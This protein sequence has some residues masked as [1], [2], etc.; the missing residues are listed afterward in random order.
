MKTIRNNFFKTF[1]LAFLLISSSAFAGGNEKSPLVKT[2]LVQQISNSFAYPDFANQLNGNQNVELTFTVNSDSTL[3][4]KSVNCD[5][6]RVEMYVFKSLN[7]KK[8]EVDKS[9]INK[10]FSM[11]VVFKKS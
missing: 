6:S 10:M 4:L 5:D 8:F 1:A 2:N 11:K 7:N 3:S 9:L